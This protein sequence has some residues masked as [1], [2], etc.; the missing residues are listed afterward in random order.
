MHEIDFDCW[1]QKYDRIPRS[2]FSQAIHPQFVGEYEDRTIISA[3]ES[4]P[5]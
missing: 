4:V 3:S 1:D 5:N 2:R